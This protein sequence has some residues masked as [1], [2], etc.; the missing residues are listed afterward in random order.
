MCVR[1][2]LNHIISEYI[3]KVT[4]L[5]L[6]ILIQTHCEPLSNGSHFTWLCWDI[7]SPALL[8]CLD[9]RTGCC[10]S[11]LYQSYFGS[12]SPSG[13]TLVCLRPAWDRHWCFYHSVN[14]VTGFFLLDW[15]K[16]TWRDTIIWCSVKTTAELII[17]FV[18]F[19][20]WVFDPAE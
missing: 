8:L 3:T 19:D 18:G 6:S 7:P 14:H 9:R 4:W 10:S 11:S 16:M 12:R 15:C 20:W 5:P 2:C 13:C 17:V 1:M